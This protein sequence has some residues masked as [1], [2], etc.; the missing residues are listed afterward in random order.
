M[1]R[2]FKILS[3]VLAIV[4]LLSF[5]TLARDYYYEDENGNIVAF[6]TK[7]NYFVIDE[8]GNYYGGDRRGNYYEGD[9][10]GNVY[11]EDRKTL[12]KEYRA[13]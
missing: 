11:Y 7:G 1:K 5:A 12:H 4:M 13:V 10:Y 2:S 8:D 3:M 6:D 9:S